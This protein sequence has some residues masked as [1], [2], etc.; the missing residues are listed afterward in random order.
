MWLYL[1]AG[2]LLL[3]GIVGGVL[4]GGIFTIVL[5]PL[6]A[7]VLIGAVIAA[8]WS[9]AQQGQAGGETEASGTEHEPL[10]HTP[11]QTPSAP[12]TPEQLVDAR[13]GQQ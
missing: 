4:S 3:I 6:G 1:I 7:V 12:T 8:M 5:L 13:R 10:R 2:F 9:R 11:S